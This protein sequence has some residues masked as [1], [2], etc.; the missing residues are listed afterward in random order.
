MASIISVTALL[1]II[2]C[3]VTGYLEQEDDEFL[4]LEIPEV[5]KVDIENGEENQR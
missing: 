5:K 1:Y 3:I 4:T 2:L